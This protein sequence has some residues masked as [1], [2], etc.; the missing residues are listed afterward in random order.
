MNRPRGLCWS[1]F[2]SPGV[3]ELYPPTSKYARRG[4]GNFA[5]AAPL[6][7]APTVAT[8]GSEEKVREMGRRA[9]AGL[10]LFHPEDAAT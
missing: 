10:S 9:A 1:C 4:V 6:A 5:G 3:R 7:E 8:P 2:Y